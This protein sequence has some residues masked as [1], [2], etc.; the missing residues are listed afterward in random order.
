MSIMNILDDKGHHVVSV[1]PDLTVMSAVQILA[2]NRI[3]AVVV[4]HD[5]SKAQAM[6]SERDIIGHLARTGEAGLATKVSEVA[7]WDV[8][9]CTPA[10]TIED[11]MRTMT[12]G[13]FRH[14]PVEED[15]SLCGIVSIGDVVKFRLRDAEHEVQS[16]RQ[17]IAAG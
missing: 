7:T 2:A 1:E 13:R 6:L 15:D 17:Y 8:T 10:C 12:E 5:R 3:G 16:I 11:V 4:S 14:V 9:I